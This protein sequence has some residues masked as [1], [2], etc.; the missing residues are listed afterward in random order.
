L[1][2]CGT[3]RP[4]VCID[5]PFNKDFSETTDKSLSKY[6]NYIFI[7]DFNYDMLN[8]DKSAILSDIC[9][10]F[11]LNKKHNKESYMFLQNC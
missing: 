6:D 2:F 7:G 8:C 9:D 1:F 10:I 5:E 11:N 4:Q 3:Y